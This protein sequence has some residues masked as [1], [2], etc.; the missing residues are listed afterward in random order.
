MRSNSSLKSLAALLALTAA[1][2][3]HTS[4]SSV[5]PSLQQALSNPAAPSLNVSSLGIQLTQQGENSSPFISP[6]GK[7]VVYVSQKRT[8]HAQ[9][10]IYV[11]D[12]DTL[13]ER[14]VT[15]QDGECRDP[16]F[17]KDSKRIV[18]ASTT[19]ELKENPLILRPK[20]E[21]SAYPFT[22]LYVSDLSGSDIERLTHQEG[23]DGYPW[24]RW[25]RP[26]SIIFSRLVDG[27]LASFQLNL[28]SKQTVPLL[29]KKDI[30]V[31]SMQ[32][33]PDKKQWTWIERAKSGATQILTGPFIL[34]SNKQMPVPLP[35][36][37]YKEV[38]WM[39]AQKLLLTARIYKKNFQF[40]TYD[41]ESKCLQS[42][43]D[44]NTDLSSPRLQI[45]KQGLVFASAQGG[46]SDI[47]YKSIPA[48]A[49]GT[50]LSSPEQKPA[51]DQKPN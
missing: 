35:A 10:Q 16:I 45:E 23:F 37:E 31:E 18:Y 43:F 44:S 32:L 30:S 13:K 42:L 26:Q 33:S 19:D 21:K 24:P 20:D 3:G 14:R 50:C 15:F 49:A 4:S 22:D 2:C 34:A 38:Q 47:F 6:D 9:G 46:H 48:S 41:L 27:Q 7:K 5:P 17:L 1:A 51:A 36:G 28:E 11:Y 8:A 40:Y 29:A 12:L 39:S 25:D